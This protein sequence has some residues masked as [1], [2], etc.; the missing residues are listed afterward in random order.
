[1]PRRASEVDTRPRQGRRPKQGRRSGTSTPSGAA[2]PWIWLVLILA[3][4]FVVYLPCLDNG[5]TEWDDNYYVT[6]NPQLANPDFWTVLT[7]PAVGNWHPLT[8]WSLSLN[9]RIGGLD[10]ASY[11]W[12]NLL[13]HLAN[14]A[15]VFVFVWR[16]SRKR[17]WTSAATSLFFGIHPM[18]VES[19]A[20]VAERKDVLYAFFMLLGLIA[21]VSHLERPNWLRLAA[22]LGA[23][24]L[25]AASKPAAVVFPVALVAID[26]FRGRA[27]T[28]S[29]W[30]EK[31]P[32][33]LVSLGVGLITLQAQQSVGAISHVWNPFQKL[34]FGVYG[35]A[36]YVA[37]LF[38]PLGLS[39][40]YPYP[41]PTT[42]PGAH[43]YI[44]FGVTLLLL[45]V[46]VWLA[47]RERA[48]AFGL[49]FYL[50]N[51]A[52]VLQ[53]FSLGG[54]T[55]ADRYTYVSY[56]GLLFALA[57]YLDE[58]ADRRAWGIPIKPVMAAIFLALVPLSLVQTWKRCDVWQNAGSLWNDTIARYPHQIADAY[59]NRGYYYLSQP[60]RLPEALTDFNEALSLN[61][62]SATIWHGRGNV[63]AAMGEDDSAIVNFDRA[64]ALQPSWAGAVNNRGA[65]KLR[66][67]QF[68]DAI[69]DFSRALEIDA[70]QRD[71]LTNRASAYASLE[72]YERSL[73]DSRRAIELD[74]AHATN[75]LQFGSIGFCE[76]KL[77]RH[78]EAVAAFDEAIR[79][80]PES[81]PR[82]GAYY[83]HRSFSLF[84]LGERA[85]ALADAREASRLKSPLPAGYL[86]SLGG[87]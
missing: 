44:V 29:V 81:E 62:Q 34:L 78:R 14:T 32:F 53:F 43:F 38:V 15:L 71:A 51:I 24:V 60:G 79:T 57:W 73:A 56:I 12:L 22:A 59:I 25:S 27:L 33:F 76:Y 9:Y 4:T 23:F 37:K 67:G 54:A 74:P 80:A 87:E 68:A 75:Y 18:H 16:L 55:M 13:L 7:K 10:P 52:L 11:H 49:G 58:R 26:L 45:P 50:I 40:I 47:R 39:A 83:L 82:R 61:S 48:V 3:V 8:M 1:L 42:G 21:Y 46:A 20:W 2:P 69:V 66:R 30:L 72:Q 65:V 63:L 17:F 64:I 86:R 36:M 41:S 6:E 70:R 31:I 77:G 19:V 5:F 85:R 35:L 84:A 28:R